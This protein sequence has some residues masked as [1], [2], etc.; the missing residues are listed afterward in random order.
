MNRYLILLLIFSHISFGQNVQTSSN[1]YT[2]QELIEDILIDSNCIENIVVTNVSGGDFNG[3]DESFGY[4][5]ANGSN[6]PFQSGIVLSTGRL[7]NV[8]GPNNTLSDDDATN[9][10]GD[11]DLETAL[12]ETNTLN[13]TVLE[14]EFT[15][16]A[17]QVSFRYIFASEEYQEGNSSTCQYSDLFGFLIKPVSA[18]TYTNIAL[19]PST[20]TPVKV[21]TVHPGI[22]GS[23][24][25]QNPAYFGSWNDNAAPINFNGQTAVL[26][27][28]TT[29]IP[30]ET[31]QVKLV[32]AD[33]QNYRYDS[34]V[35]LEAGSFKLF[36]N[37]GDDRLLTQGNAL[38][39]GDS[40]ELN[41][42]EPGLTTYQWFRNG[43]EIPGETNA[44]YTINEAGIYEVEVTL[45]N[46]CQSSGRILVDYS[47]NPNIVNTVLKECDFDM[48][49]I[50]EF[51]LNDAI[52]NIVNGD[53]NLSLDN[54]FLTLLDA[55][56]NINPV[57]NS[58]SFQNTVED[59]IIFARIT[60]D[61]NCLSIAEV[62]LLISTAVINIAS[63]KQCDDVQVDGFTEFVTQDI[64][65]TFQSMLPSDAIV[66]FY[67]SLQDVYAESNAIGPIFENTV[68]NEQTIYVKIE[69]NNQCYAIS[70]INLHVLYTPVLEP[71]I[72]PDNPIFYCLNTYPQTIRLYGGVL[73][74]LPNNYYYLWNT[75]ENTSFIDINEIGT[76]SVTVTDPNGCSSS[77]SFTIS[78]SET[79]VINGVSV[80]ASTINNTVSVDATGSGNYQYSLDNP[81]GPYQMSPLFTNV[82]AGF[83]TIYVR[84]INDCTT[85]S[86]LISVL[87]FPKFLTPNN[88]GYH[89]TW[90]ALG[91]NTIFQ[92]G[93][94]INI[95]SKEGKL[96]ASLTNY[97]PGWDGTFKGRKLPSSDY[98]FT[99]TLINGQVYTGYFSL[100]R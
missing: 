44:I 17:D 3:T 36:T 90:H 58:D 15:A 95:F 16:I 9:W 35:F 61:N 83:H 64:T 53:S 33:E 62:Q 40:L 91:V 13:A 98:W 86:K 74:D 77:R 60:N 18:S 11:S 39:E 56:L 30:N 65:D 100:K 31:Y 1:I 49:G 59:Q 8:N 7:E 80:A 73:N 25:A 70:S 47:I 12:N 20:T 4:F 6:F 21:T 72:T 37:L 68:I 96:V 24:S 38:C 89:D 50:T 54:F 85:A 5:D 2:A 52:P 34:A 84:D 29:I 78:A 97:T 57:T 67:E 79:A 32:I 66:T 14:F 75:G 46:N 48:D 92:E 63:F 26:E 19:I 55:E 41:A 45:E 42:F 28:T 10:Q 82:K 51:N 71:N 27:A 76:Y 43:L 69:S 81:E 99:A 87:G 94:Q 23:C 93:I 88:D 22:P